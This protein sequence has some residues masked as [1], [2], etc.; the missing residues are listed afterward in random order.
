[1]TALVFRALFD[2]D[3]GTPIVCLL[4]TDVHVAQRQ[5]LGKPAEE[6][7]GAR[8]AGHSQGE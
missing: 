8:S 3:I 7:H 2:T 4:R 5:E 1:M 6:R